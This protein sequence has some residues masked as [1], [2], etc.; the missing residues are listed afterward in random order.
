MA[1]QSLSAGHC[2]VALTKRKAAAPSQG[3]MPTMV[4]NQARKL[5][6]LWHE[7]SSHAVLTCAA[8]CDYCHRM[9]G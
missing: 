9:Q 6:T 2:K 7:L 3:L 1:M 5:S 4:S 8:H